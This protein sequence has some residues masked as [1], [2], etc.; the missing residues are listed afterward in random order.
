[1]H[2]HVSPSVNNFFC[3]SQTFRSADFRKAFADISS[4]R[5]II[6][7]ETP[8][9]GLSGTLTTKQLESLPSQ[10]GMDKPEGYIVVS[11]SP[12]RPNITLYRAHK[13]HSDSKLSEY[14]AIYKPEVDKLYYCPDSY[15]VTLMYLPMQWCSAASRYC[16]QIFGQQSMDTCRYAQIYSQQSKAVIEVVTREL[17]KAVPR[18]RLVFCTSAIGMGFDSG[19]ITRVIHAKP[20]R[21]LSDYFQEISRC[22]RAGQ[23]AE[24]SLHFSCSDIAANIPGIK[25]DIVEY[26]KTTGCL[27]ASMLSAYGFDKSPASPAGCSCCSVCKVACNCDSCL[28]DLLD[29]PMEIA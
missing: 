4:I 3:I 22:G 17:K 9:V 23:P 16:L 1:M 27:R 24:A 20:P 15:P 26:C 10:L 21:N 14:E 6:P 28:A 12:D 5:S 25:P 7:E 2:V 11:T 29:E 13:P 19:S 8:V 18:I